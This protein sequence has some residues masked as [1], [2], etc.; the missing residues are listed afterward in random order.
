MKRVLNTGD[1]TTSTESPHDSNTPADLPAE[2]TQSVPVLSH[3]TPIN[4]SMEIVGESTQ[5][6]ITT[7][8]YELLLTTPEIRAQIHN[9]VAEA[10]IRFSA[11]RNGMQTLRMDGERW[12]KELA[13]EM[14]VACVQDPH[15][16]I[17][18]IFYACRN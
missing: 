10:D 15:A 2:Q 14:P 8:E 5:S 12:L 9:Q 18:S 13:A 11:Q 3:R 17:P 1:I 4:S 6:P 7:G 16:L